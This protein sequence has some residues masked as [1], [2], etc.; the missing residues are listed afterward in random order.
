[1]KFRDIDISVVVGE[2]PLE[3]LEVAFN[4]EKQEATCWIASEAG[5]VCCNL[6]LAI[7]TLESRL[8]LLGVRRSS[9]QQSAHTW[10]CLPNT[11][12]WS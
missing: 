8:N 12:R 9:R 1:M 10:S 3:E 6:C 2:N 7:D 5:A 4:E 11:H